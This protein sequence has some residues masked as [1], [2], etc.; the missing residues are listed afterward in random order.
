MP[1][2][3]E[4]T[5]DV[6]EEIH[7]AATPAKAFEALLQRLGPLN[8]TPDGASLNMTLEPRPG[9]RWFRNLD[10]DTGHLWGHV[11]VIKPPTLLE[12]SGPLFMSYPAL[13]HVQF[14]I[15]EHKAGA[16]LS[17]RHQ[18][19]GLIDPE[20]RAGVTQGWH[21]MIQGVKDHAERH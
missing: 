3:P 12:I 9:G 13:S 14:R 17:F 15:A 8:A 1:I 6:Q 11:Q 20:H 2:P 5:L 7:I 21:H 16:T 18:A 10:N 4:F 19:L